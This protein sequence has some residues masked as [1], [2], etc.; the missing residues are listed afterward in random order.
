M[1]FILNVEGTELGVETIQTVK[2]A[3]DTP[4]GTNA[5]TTDAAVTATIKGKILTMLD[6]GSE[7]SMDLA[8][9]AM[10]TAD[11]ADCYRNVTIKSLAA[12]QVVREYTFT[13]AFVIDYKEDYD[14]KEGIG[15]FTLIIRQKKDKIKDATVTG[16]YAG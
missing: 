5:K 13:K 2:F 4:D 11:N 15:T 8:K 12:G 7:A 1:G 3:V 6:E 14:D 16:G 9:W 10:V